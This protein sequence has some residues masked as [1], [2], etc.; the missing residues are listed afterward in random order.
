[1]LQCALVTAAVNASPSSVLGSLEPDTAALRPVTLSSMPGQVAA[2]T[3]PW[4]QRSA[5]RPLSAS[6]LA[7]IAAPRAACETCF[8]LEDNASSCARADICWSTRACQV[9]RH[10][11]GRL[12]VQ[13]GPPLGLPLAQRHAVMAAAPPMVVHCRA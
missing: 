5:L 13:A 8:A 10:K 4:M 12:W 9:C 1:M 3:L 2:Q 11:V 7:F 6:F